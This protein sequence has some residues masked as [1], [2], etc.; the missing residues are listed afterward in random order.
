M[1]P[2]NWLNNW[3]TANEECWIDFKSFIPRRENSW[4]GTSISQAAGQ[5]LSLTQK[6]VLTVAKLMIDS[7]WPTM[8]LSSNKLM[9]LCETC[10]AL[11]LYLNDIEPFV[12]HVNLRL[13]SHCM[14]CWSVRGKRRARMKASSWK[15]LGSL[16]QLCKRGICEEF[17][18][19]KLESHK[20]KFE[21]PSS[22]PFKPSKNLQSNHDL[23]CSASPKKR[24]CLLRA[25]SV[26]SRDGSFV[27]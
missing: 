2:S 3:G 9:D 27:G 13:S 14:N 23:T 20:Q 16:R 1:E 10:V 15:N 22:F 18:S 17:D 7:K 11:Y 26:V 21:K 19:E 5:K 6:K 4:V 24:K 12:C 25:S 8:V